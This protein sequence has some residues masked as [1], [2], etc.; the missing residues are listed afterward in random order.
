[1]ITDDKKFN[2]LIDTAEQ[3]YKRF[4]DPQKGFYSGCVTNKGTGKP[5]HT[6]NQFPGVHMFISKQLKRKLNAAETT[7]LSVAIGE[8]PTPL[9][10][11]EER[12]DAF[13]YMFPLGKSE[14]DKKFV[15]LEK[16]MSGI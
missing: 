2:L 9:M 13:A 3:L 6:F 1:M 10:T 11:P 7:V 8:G 4:C 15:S 12:A 14:Y 5:L 16:L